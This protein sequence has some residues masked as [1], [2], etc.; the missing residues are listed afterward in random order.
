MRAVPDSTHCRYLPQ[1]PTTN[2]RRRKVIRSMS[3]PLLEAKHGTAATTAPGKPLCSSQLENVAA[4][5]GSSMKGYDLGLPAS[6][7]G[8]KKSLPLLPPLSSHTLRPLL[9]S[10][11]V[12]KVVIIGT[13]SG[14]NVELDSARCCHSRLGCSAASG[15]GGF[16]EAPKPRTPTHAVMRQISRSLLGQG[17]DLAAGRGPCSSGPSSSTSC[18]GGNESRQ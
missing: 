12:V 18:G 7:S 15:Y 5:C 6:R 11:N 4:S 2:T 3:V 16:L 9:A 13:L 1:A 10:S 17:Y 8:S 14:D